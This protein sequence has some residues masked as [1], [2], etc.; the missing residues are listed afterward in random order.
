MSVNRTVL[1]LVGLLVL[2]VLIGYIAG[3]TLEK[4]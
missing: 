3:Q 4:A 2:I 1:I